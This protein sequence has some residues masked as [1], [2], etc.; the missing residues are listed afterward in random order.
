MGKVA[1]TEENILKCICAECPSKPMD[2]LSFYCAKGKSPEAVRRR[3]C[4][5][6]DC[7]VFREYGLTKGY[8]CAEGVTE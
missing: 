7:V 6:G 8:Y 4:L 3:G 1:D 2:H 5:C